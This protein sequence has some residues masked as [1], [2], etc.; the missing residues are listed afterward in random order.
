MPAIST[1]VSLGPPHLGK[2][3]C[4]PEPA[5]GDFARQASSPGIAFVISQV[6]RMTPSLLPQNVRR[7]KDFGNSSVRKYGAVNSHGKIGHLSEA[8]FKMSL[9]CSVPPVTLARKPILPPK[10]LF[11]M[12]KKTG[13]LS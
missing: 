2:V 7:L 6:E 4:C 10:Q 5:P 8:V 11:T 12:L 3:A 13:S 9:A 1:T